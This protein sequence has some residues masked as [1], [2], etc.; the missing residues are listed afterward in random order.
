MA[1]G[2]LLV[3]DSVGI[4]GAP[5]AAKFGD[6]GADTLGHIAAA[7]AS[8]AADAAGLRAGP[9]TIPIMNRLGLCRAAEASAGQHPAGVH[10]VK[11]PAAIWGY[12]NEVSR[13]KDTQSG[14]WELAGLPVP[15]VWGYFPQVENPIPPAIVEPLIAEAGLP[16]I[17]GNV[18]AS[19]TEV[20]E[21]FGAEHVRTGKP[22]LYTSV[23]SVL[24]IC[25]HEERFGLERLYET[26]RIAR[27]LCDKLNIGRVIAR[28]FTGESPADFQRT[29]NR[30]DFAVPP[31]AETLLDL[32][33]ERGRDV[34][35]VG[36]IADIFTGRGVTRV[37][38]AADNAAQVDATIEALG[39]A[40][41]GD[42]VFANFI[43][44]DQVHGHRRDVAGY[45]A[46]LE[47]FDRRLPEILGVL[48]PGDLVILTADH[49]NDPTFKG[50]D[51][52]RENIP[53]LA[54][55]PGIEGREAG[56]LRTF[57]DV[58]QTLAAHLMLPVMRSGAGLM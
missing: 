40:K 58:A 14:H 21:R 6:E 26:C 22:I 42:L 32:A 30:K 49:G 38:K 11:R 35:G 25:A 24:Q 8:G 37:L 45:A 20:I 54:F 12:A 57:A 7:C 56:R 44:F 28:P 18:H 16:G 34:F 19:G 46:C 47:A 29:G 9:L 39:E 13:G 36:K 51:H 15:F 53:V 17:L 27:K 48:R 10:R 1:R 52:T 23:D 41:D 55:G 50:T 43:D 33:V 5:D 2:I 4:G 31:P 3:M